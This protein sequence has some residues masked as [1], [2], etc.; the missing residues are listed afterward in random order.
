MRDDS[1]NAEMLSEE[2]R[3]LSASIG[4]ACTAAPAHDPQWRKLA[5]TRFQYLFEQSR[6]GSARPSLGVMK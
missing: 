1:P 6:S 2:I 3:K 4:N 5:S